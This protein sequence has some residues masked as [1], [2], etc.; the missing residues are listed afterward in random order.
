MPAFS[1]LQAPYD[2]ATAGTLFIGINVATT[3]EQMAQAILLSIVFRVFQI[4][5]Q[6][7]RETHQRPTVVRWLLPLEELR[8]IFNRAEYAAVSHATTIFA[9]N[10]RR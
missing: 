4:Y 5:D 9:N 8:N 6:M 10:W 7:C 1:G 3:K 2:D